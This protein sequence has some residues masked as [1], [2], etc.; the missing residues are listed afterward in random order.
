[1]RGIAFRHISLQLASS[2]LYDITLELDDCLLLLVDAVSRRMRMDIQRM[3]C[4]V[5]LWQ[6]ILLQVAVYLDVGVNPEGDVVLFYDFA[7]E[8][9]DNPLLLDWRKMLELVWNWPKLPAKRMLHLHVVGKADVVYVWAKLL[10]WQ[11][12]VIAVSY[13]GVADYLVFA[14]HGS[15]S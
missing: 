1:M 8:Y 4:Q 9:L 12:V 15:S 3:L 11:Q 2:V 14:H 10:D 5:V 7:C 13:A 6:D